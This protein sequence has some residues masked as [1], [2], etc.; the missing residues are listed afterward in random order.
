[1]KEGL[2]Q[3]GCGGETPIAQRNENRRGWVKG[4]P[5]KFLPGHNA[6]RGHFSKF[7]KKEKLPFLHSEGYLW[8]YTPSHPKAR[9]GYVLEHVLV[10]ERALG[11][12]LPPKAEPHHVDGNRSNNLNLNL[13]LCQDRAYHMLLEMRT[14]AYEACGHASWRKCNY[15]HEYDDPAHLYIGS[16]V[17]HRG[18]QNEYQKKRRAKK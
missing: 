18:C 16:N 9:N 3:C 7:W 13:V 8:I 1:M 5:L 17:F 2:C 4:K 14:R 12:Y 15:C 11:K 10:C 6:P